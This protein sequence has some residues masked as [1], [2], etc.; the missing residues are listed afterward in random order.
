MK[1]FI[2]KFYQN[3]GTYIST[4]PV[5]L[6]VVPDRSQV[7]PMGTPR[8][9]NEINSGS[10]QI[11]IDTNQAFDDFDSSIIACNNV[12][13]L[14]VFDDVNHT[15]PILMY[16]GIISK[17][18]PFYSEGKEGV[19]INCLGRSSELNTD[20][21]TSGGSYEFNKAGKA[22]AIFQDIITNF[23][24]VYTNTD[25]NYTGGSVEDSLVTLDIDFSKKKWKGAIDDILKLAPTGWWWS[26]EADGT[27]NFKSK[28]STA[29][30]TFNIQRE[31][32]EIQTP[33]DMEVVINKVI[34]ESSAPATPHT[35][36]DTTSITANGTRTAYI[37]DTNIKDNASAEA[38]V[39]AE[40]ANKKDR[41][42]T[43]TVT[44][45]SLYDIESIKVGD[46]CKFVNYKTTGGL[47]LGTNMQI[48]RVEY[49]GM[50]AKLTLEDTEFFSLSKQITK[51]TA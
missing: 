36:S 5:R 16:T 12:I 3:D 33:I 39:N 15:T 8:I 10:G 19:K 42:Y 4:L 46:T 30:H 41:K 28:P 37:T 7:L 50:T 27:A 45:N 25:I 17:V 23:R 32:Q 26:I 43:A 34:L 24:N 49:D 51:L 20:Y 44:I 13:K 21:Y 40:L 18:I 1:K 38:R 9:V 11:T 29:T 2:Y 47:S 35:V 14:Y 6:P 22:S 48:V 31:V